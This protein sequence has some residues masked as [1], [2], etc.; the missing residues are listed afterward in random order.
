M[1]KYSECDILN[2]IKEH[3]NS[4]SPDIQTGVF[5]LQQLMEESVK[6]NGLPDKVKHTLSKLGYDIDVALSN[7][8]SARNDI[9]DVIGSLEESQGYLRSLK[10][11]D[12]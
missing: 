6:I 8:Q 2:F 1:I 4:I 12:V 9:E 3:E 5:M 7:A 10:E 11:Y